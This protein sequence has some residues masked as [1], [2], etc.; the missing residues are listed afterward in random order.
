M[1]MKTVVVVG[2]GITGLC[3]MHYLKNKMHEQNVEARLILIEKNEYLGGKIHSE[4]DKGFIMETGADSIVA[5]YPS[6]LELVKELDFES[7]IVY[8]ETG[9]SYIHTNN[10]LHAIPKGSIFGIPMDIDSLN[11]STLIS[12]EG[13][14]R[15][16]KDE[17]LPNTKFTKESSIGEFLEYFL[18]EEIVEKQIA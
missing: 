11:A 7:E 16:L 1:D 13:K 5:R 14:K 4:K 17:E 15:V 18:G 9:I 10:E 8:N 6:V 12:E 3:T 2:G